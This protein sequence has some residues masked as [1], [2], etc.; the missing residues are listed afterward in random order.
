MDLIYIVKINTI[1]NCVHAIKSLHSVTVQG[2]DML[3]SVCM[4][5]V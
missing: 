3:I 2:D 5:H 1:H 4:V